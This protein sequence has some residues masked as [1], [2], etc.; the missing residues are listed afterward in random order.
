MES[1]FQDASGPAR[2]PTVAKLASSVSGH[3]AQFRATKARN[4]HP[5]LVPSNFDGRAVR[6]PLVRFHPI[7]D[8]R[9]YLPHDGHDLLENDAISPGDS[10]LM[11]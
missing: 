5:A 2:A 10:V 4:G 7:C 8:E 6:N 1:T 3:A 11:N 9:C